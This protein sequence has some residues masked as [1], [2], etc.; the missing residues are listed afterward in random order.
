MIKPAWDRAPPEK[1][2]GATGIGSASL[3]IGSAAAQK[4]YGLGKGGPPQR[5]LQGLVAG[6]PGTCEKVFQSPHLLT[7]SERHHLAGNWSLHASDERP[8][9]AGQQHHSA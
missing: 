8:N 6:N 2:S 7:S 5:N 1:L 9:I 4:F 3:F